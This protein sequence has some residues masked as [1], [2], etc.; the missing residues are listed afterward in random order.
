MALRAIQIWR[1]D[2]EAC[3]RWASRISLFFIAFILDEIHCR[4]FAS[5]ARYSLLD[6]GIDG[7]DELEKARIRSANC[8]SVSYSPLCNA[9]EGQ[10][11]IAR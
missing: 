1:A 5:V 6:H 8:G 4:S 2:F 11:A 7:A 9:L 10:F 3:A